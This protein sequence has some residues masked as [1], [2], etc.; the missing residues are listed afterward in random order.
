MVV[1]PFCCWGAYLVENDP[2][3]SITAK[4][5]ADWTG[6][7]VFEREHGFIE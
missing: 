2:D 5:I 1:K 3:I 7:L 6:N 4:T